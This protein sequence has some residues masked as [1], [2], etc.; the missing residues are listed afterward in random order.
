VDY[1]AVLIYLVLA[2]LVFGFFFRVQLRAWW[3]RRKLKARSRGVIARSRRWCATPAGNGA[4]GVS[5]SASGRRSGE[6]DQAEMR[7]E[8]PAHAQH[9]GTHREGIDGDAGERRQL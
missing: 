8:R 9:R 1:A 2:V 5:A 3:I 6:V 4:R 7:P